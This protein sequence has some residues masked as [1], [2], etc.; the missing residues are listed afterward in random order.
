VKV[1]EPSVTAVPT[2]VLVGA[3]VTGVVP[4]VIVGGVDEVGGVV[5]VGGADDEGDAGAGADVGVDV[6]GA[7]A[8]PAGALGALP[9]ADTWDGAAVF[10]VAAVA[11]GEPVAVDVDAAVVVPPVLPVDREDE[12]KD[13][14]DDGVV[15][16]RGVGTGT[17]ALGRPEEYAAPPVDVNGAAEPVETEFEVLGELGSSAR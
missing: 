11:A 17:L 10:T 9:D 2:T 6:V 16:D 4:D 15:D 3:V 14:L 1:P 7:G 12:L 13:P 5:D 8:V